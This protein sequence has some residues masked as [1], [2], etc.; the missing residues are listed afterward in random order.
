V[1]EDLRATPTTATTSPC[2]ALLVPV[3]GG[4]PIT[5]TIYLT[6]DAVKLTTPSASQATYLATVVC[7]P[8]ATGTL[9]AS[10]AR[11]LITWRALANQANGVTPTQYQGSFQTVV[12]LDRN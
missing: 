10:T 1:S 9:N 7:T 8:A 4:S 3:T 11:I 12:G 6:G 5:N 2:Y